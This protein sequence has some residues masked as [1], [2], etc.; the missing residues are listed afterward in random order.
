[1]AS[2]RR[3]LGAL[4]E[5]VAS[6]HVLEVQGPLLLRLLGLL[7]LLVAGF[8]LRRGGIHLGLRVEDGGV[9]APD[10]ADD[11]EHLAVDAAGRDGGVIVVR[12][13]LVV[14]VVVLLL[15]LRRDEALLLALLQALQRLPPF[16][17]LE[18]AGVLLVDLDLGE[19][20][21]AAASIGLIVGAREDVL[22]LLLLLPPLLHGCRCSGDGDDGGG[23]A[24]GN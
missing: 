19:I 24:G 15:L 9:A 11:L 8:T 21:L 10:A 2:L 22:L 1:M 16:V 13:G 12:R 4:L 17:V 18:A 5:Q 3:E 7:P 20:L 23:E 14:V 6:V